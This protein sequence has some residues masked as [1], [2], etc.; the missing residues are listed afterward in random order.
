MVKMEDF[1]GLVR[2]MRNAQ[3]KYFYTRAYAHLMVA[4]RLE[5]EVDKLLKEPMEKKAMPQCRLF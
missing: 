4:R 1:I 3:K 5:S 2:D